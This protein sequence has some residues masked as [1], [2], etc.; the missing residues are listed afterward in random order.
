MKK[1][2]SNMD[3]ED[4]PILQEAIQK[5]KKCLEEARELEEFI[6]RYKE[7]AGL[8]QVSELTQY[9]R[10]AKSGKAGYRLLTMKE[11]IEWAEHILRERGIVAKASDFI[12]EFEKAGCTISQNNTMSSYLSQTK[13]KFKFDKEAGGWVLVEPYQ[14]WLQLDES[15]HAIVR[16]TYSNKDDKVIPVLNT[17]AHPYAFIESKTEDES[18]EQN[19]LN[20]VLRSCIAPSS[21]P[22]HPQIDSGEKTVCESGGT[23]RRD[24]LSFHYPK[25]GFAG[26]SPVSRTPSL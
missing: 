16:T 10:R 22:K 9:D 17:L 13:D 11:S 2:S 1:T 26:S 6:Y 24:G 8:E 25:A 4:H 23:G 19:N 14:T 18:D 5:H 3:F 21:F 20:W 15:T 7:M 12:R